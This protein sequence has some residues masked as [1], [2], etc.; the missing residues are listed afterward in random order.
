MKK[1]LDAI[2]TKLRPLSNTFRRYRLT[3]FI[4][5]F[6]GT[7]TFLVVHINTLTNQEPDPAELA[8]R[9]QVTKRLS[10][11]QDSI[12]RILE[13]EEQNID[14]KALFEQARNNPFNE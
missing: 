14:V 7:Y 5:T 8:S 1:D 2:L 11:D 12:D 4:L 10:I 9:K 13:L 3:L 6:L